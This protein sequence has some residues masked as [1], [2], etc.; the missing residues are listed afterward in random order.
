MKQRRSNSGQALVEF[1]LFLV[2]LVLCTFLIFQ[3]AWIAVQKWQFNYFAM[4][5][6]RAWA[7]DK[8]RDSGESVLL[9]AQG[10]ALLRWDLIGT[11]YVK[12]MWCSSEDGKDGTEGL[13]YT[14]VAPLMSIF[15][16]YI[17]DTLTGIEIPAVAETVIPGLEI[18]STGLVRF[19]TFIP[20][21][22]E[23]DEDPDRWDN[24]CS[25]PCDDNER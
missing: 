24:D 14:G 16:P 9:K 17:G 18:P 23:P 25:D 21:E 7:V 8:D 10:F 19:E 15:Q 6:T 11:D 4:Y 1:T 3:L 20:M 5:A 22:H 2:A 13:S 12:F